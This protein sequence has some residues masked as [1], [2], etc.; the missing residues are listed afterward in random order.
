MKAVALCLYFSKIQTTFV[1]EKTLFHHH[2]GGSKRMISEHVQL[3]TL[4][5]RY[6]RYFRLESLDSVPT[7]K[8]REP[9]Q[10][11]SLT[12]HEA[13]NLEELP[14][15]GLFAGVHGLE[16]IGVQ[17]LVHF[18]DF[19]LKQTDWNEQFRDLLTKVRMVGIPIVNPAGLVHM[20]RSNGHGVDLMR[21]APVESACPSVFI[22]GHRWSAWLPYF[23]GKQDLELESRLLLRLVQ[24]QCFNAPFSITMD[25]HSGFGV[26]D[27]LWTPYAKQQGLPP[28]WEEYRRIA[29]LIDNSLKYAK[30]DFAPQS[31][32]YCTNGD[33]WDYLYD[34]YLEQNPGE[35]GHF[36]PL[37]LEV[38]TW[39]FI[40][41]SPLTGFRTWNYFNPAHAHRF[42]RVIRRHIQLLNLLAHLTAN[43]EQ[44]FIT[45]SDR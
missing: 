8:G 2:N 17:I 13:E 22:G 5:K 20:T 39:R 15:L 34:R 18:L 10:R 26:R 38:G 25:L 1:E 35:E 27:C 12:D 14:V 30:Y 23:R 28:T 4:A 33:L 32:Y 44:A 24:E 9:I 21:N 3:Q 40:K 43:W 36:L 29:Q 7:R 31:R 6:P 16:V 37:T 41:K 42:R 45:P 11:F 19:A